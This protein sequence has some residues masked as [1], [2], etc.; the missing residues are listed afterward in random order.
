MPLRT[1]LIPF[2]K[3][4]QKVTE[5]WLARKKW[6][7]FHISP[8]QGIR[9]W[10][11][12]QLDQL[13]DAQ[14]EVG[15]Q[16]DGTLRQGFTGLYHQQAQIHH[17]LLD[18]TDTLNES[19]KGIAVELRTSRE[20]MGKQLSE[21]TE[22]TEQVGDLIVETGAQLEAG[23]AGLGAQMDMG[24]SGLMSQFELQRA[25]MQEGLEK[26]ANLLS[27]QEKTRARERFQDGK[28][29]YDQYAQHPDEPQFLMDAAHYLQESV[30][31]YRGNPFAQM[32]LGFVYQEPTDL[33]DL[34]K[35]T[36]H[37]LLAA[38]YAKGIQQPKLAARAYFQA[39]WNQY[40]L[41]DLEEA[42]RLGELC[43]SM[44]ALGIPECYYNLAKFH[45]SLGQAEQAITYLDAA[46]QDF[47]AAYTIKADLDS[48]F[49]PI[50]ETLH[51]YFEKIRNQAA[52][53]W[54]QQMKR[55]GIG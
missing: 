8:Q 23:M 51:E 18:Q 29:A 52:A 3:P 2:A 34:G 50:K 17:A 36:E 40:L 44:D 53:T 24:F 49:E 12:Q 15:H 1:L 25:E 27:N 38:T 21:L 6:L 14:Y 47:D 10:P 26:I 46:V 54:D 7:R 16:L 11:K 13:I 31:M 5:H 37:C 42:I 55:L 22:K 48:D 39:A 45:G 9:L 30:S 4:A 43:L 33:F 41:G 28:L 32:L 35:S 20:E 19:L